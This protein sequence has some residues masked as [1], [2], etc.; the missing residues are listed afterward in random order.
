MQEVNNDETNTPMVK[1][2][3]KDTGIGVSKEYKDVIFEKY[4][5][6]NISVARQF[7]GTGLGLSICQYLV[8]NMGGK[9]GVDSEPGKGASFWFYLPAQVPT[10]TE[11]TESIEDDMVGDIGGLHI[12]VAEDNKVNQKLVVNM[13]RRMGHTS[14]VAEN[15]RDAITMIEKGKF[16]AVLMDI[17]VCFMIICF[18]CSR[19]T[20]LLFGTERN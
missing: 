12:L 6:A 11:S 17:Q 4:Q 2:V 10:E 9:I 19:N 15:G 1:F 3:V 7:G 14:T 8:H 13:L 16:D 20:C 18:L 5:Q